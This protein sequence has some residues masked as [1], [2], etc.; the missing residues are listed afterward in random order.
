MLEANA[1]DAERIPSGFDGSPV[2]AVILP[3]PKYVEL[4]ASQDARSFTYHHLQ[5]PQYS[6]LDPFAFDADEFV[7]M[8]LAYC[9]EHRVNAV[10]AFDCFPTLLSS[11][12]REALQLPG[13][14][15][16]SV[17]LCCNKYYMRRE[18]TPAVPIGVL[19]A[20]PSS[21]PA[22]L[23]VSDTQFYVGTRLCLAAADWA[24]K[25]AEIKQGLPTGR[26]EKRQQFYYKWACHFGWA[27]T[28]G[29]T[30]PSDITLVHIEPLFANVGEYQ[31]EVVVHADGSY[32]MADTGDIEHGPKQVITIFKTPGTFTITPVLRE[33]LAG[34]V[35][36]LVQLGYKTAAMD[37]EFVRLQGA[38]EA[39]Q[40]IEVNSRYSYMGNYIHF[41]IAAQAEVGLGFDAK[42]KPK[43]VRN[44]LNRTR[45]ALGAPHLTMPSRDA[46]G[47]SKLAAMVYTDRKGSLET[48]FD[49]EALAAMLADWTLDAFAPT[50]LYV[51]GDV[52]EADLREYNGWA[53]IGVLLL[54]MEDDLEAINSKLDGVMRRLFFGSERGF[55]PV[56]VIDE[57]GPGATGLNPAALQV[58]EDDERAS[59]AAASKCCCIL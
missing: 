45:L 28:Y 21:F 14:S 40:L 58:A 27:G 13:P 1:H 53:K 39:Y 42:N 17:F 44:L 4:I 37:V 52:T 46:V 18:L 49:K 25:C 24:G 30:A 31:C 9:R 16:R 22:V 34:V 20:S 32:L 29:W 6:M 7:E 2:V 3:S 33:W 15:F 57:D 11:I 5:H 48:I 54:T 55:L 41:G 26:V 47:I 36:R 19:P 35:E 12:I 10:M 8:A 23:K 56:V 59:P 38:G 50:K 51:R 43:E